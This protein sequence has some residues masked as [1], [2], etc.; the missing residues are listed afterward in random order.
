VSSRFGVFANF[1]SR[2]LRSGRIFA[3]SVGINGVELEQG[4]SAFGADATTG[5]GA[6][7][8]FLSVGMRS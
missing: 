1:K 7:A 3:R 4:M 2:W 8:S 6:N 5:F